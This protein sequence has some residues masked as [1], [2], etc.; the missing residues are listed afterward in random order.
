M[1][2]KKKILLLFGTRPEAI[3]MASLYIELISNGQEFETLICLTGQHKE[4]LQQAM[5][6]FG[7][8]EDFNL[9]V[10]NNGL[11]LAT[12]LSEIISK[13]SIILE[14]NRPDLL[15]VHGDTASTLAASLAGF[16]M[17]IKVG[18][19]EAGLRTYNLLSPYP[20]E[21]NRQIVSK[22]SSIHFAPTISA[23]DN[24]I[25]DGVSDDKIVVTGNTVIDSLHIAL[26]SIYKD[27][28]LLHKFSA[29]LDGLLDFNW[30]SDRYVLITVHRRENLWDG[31]I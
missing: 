16:L 23:K 30:K 10:Q 5:N 12:L 8:N 21:F 4:M 6:I 7:I 2:N 14:V 22:A 29:S 17:N 27:A 15:L 26:E 11:N 9:N 3:K 31:L 1:I 20:E 18:H 28:K 19:I 25:R 24:L 13:L